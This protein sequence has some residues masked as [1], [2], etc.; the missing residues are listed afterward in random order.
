M[1]DR[2][3]KRILGQM[4]YGVSVVAATHE[5]ITRAFTSTWTYQVSFDEPLI[6]SSVS[7]KHDTTPILDAAGWYS[8]SMLAGDQVEEGQY[9]SYPGHRFRYVGDYLTTTEGVPHVRDCIG[10]LRADVVDRIEVRDHILLLGE[11]VGFGGGRLSEPALTYSSRKGWRVASAPA[12]APGTSVR[13]RLLAM[14]DDHP[15]GPHEAS[16]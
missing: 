9:F 12:R 11:V 15:P 3:L 4:T 14:L 5:G 6:A 1:I 16:G 8:V 13:D 2:E 10:W 7:P